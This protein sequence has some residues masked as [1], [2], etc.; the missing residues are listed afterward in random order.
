MK[1]HKLF[2]LFSNYNYIMEQETSLDILDDSEC[3]DL[4]SELEANSTVELCTGSKKLFPK[5][6]LYAV[7]F[8]DTDQG[9]KKIGN[10]IDY[11]GATQRK[12]DFYLGGTDSCQGKIFNLKLI[13]YIKHILFSYYTILF[14]VSIY[15]QLFL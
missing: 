14:Q 7:W 4:G 5:I 11:L 1:I 15:I 3:D 10:E 6:E 8:N 9:F 2:D 13:Y 12:Y